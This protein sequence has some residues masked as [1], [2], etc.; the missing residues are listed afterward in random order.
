M[1]NFNYKTSIYNIHIIMK[2]IKRYI[3]WSHLY[4]K[5]QTNTYKTREEAQNAIN[6][7]PWDA[8]EEIFEIN[9][10]L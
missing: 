2:T 9:V 10:E 3:I 5:L 1:W 7:D 6:E 8:E 4:G